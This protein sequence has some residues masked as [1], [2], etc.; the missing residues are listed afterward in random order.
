MHE[1]MSLTDT[2]KSNGALIADY[3]FIRY[4]ECLCKHI[5]K[6]NYRPMAYHQRIFGSPR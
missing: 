4:S 2:S 5:N 1:Y 3:I 6:V